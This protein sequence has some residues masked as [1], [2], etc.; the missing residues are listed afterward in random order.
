M[1]MYDFF[2]VLQW[3]GKTYMSED[4][5]E[6]QLDKHKKDAERL[7]KKEQELD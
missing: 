6:H 7:R 1:I 3:I 2:F 5:I 4:G